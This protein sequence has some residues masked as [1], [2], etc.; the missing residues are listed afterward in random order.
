MPYGG[1]CYGVP[2]RGWSYRV[3]YG[4]CS[5]KRAFVDCSS[6]RLLYWPASLQDIAGALL[7]LHFCANDRLMMVGLDID[8]APSPSVHRV[9]LSHCNGCPVI[10]VR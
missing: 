8:K 5:Y 1:C 10:L 3:P 7:W 6:L 4:G 9:V 2:Y